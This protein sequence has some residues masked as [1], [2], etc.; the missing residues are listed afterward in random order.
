[1][2]TANAHSMTPQVRIDLII[3]MYLLVFGERLPARHHDEE[4][5]L[6]FGCSRQMSRSAMLDRAQV[7]SS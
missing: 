1:V 7:W 6:R 3:G 4:A 5:R 2:T